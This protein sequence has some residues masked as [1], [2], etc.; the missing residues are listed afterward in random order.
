MINASG[1]QNQ[2]IPD[3]APL[4]QQEPGL[5]ESDIPRFSVHATCLSFLMALNV[6][7]IPV[8]LYEGV[9]QGHIKR[10]NEILLAGPGA[11]LSLG[12]VILIY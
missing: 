5:G 2:A 3:G 6:A 4:L 9:Q 12:G 7:S 1:T 10:G 11:G 8:T